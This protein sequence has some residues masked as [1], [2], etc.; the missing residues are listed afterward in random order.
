MKSARFL[1]CC[2]VQKSVLKQIR[3]E[4]ETENNE[5]KSETW[6][7]M[8]IYGKAQMRNSGLPKSL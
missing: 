5:N 6:L 1:K 4:K 3:E 2:I 7:D 8:N